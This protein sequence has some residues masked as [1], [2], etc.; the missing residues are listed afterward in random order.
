MANLLL[1]L[2][3]KHAAALDAAD[4]LLATVGARPMTAEEQTQYDGHLSEADGLRVQL[5]NHE[6]RAAI[7][8]IPSDT[9]PGASTRQVR[10]FNNA[11]DKPWGYDLIGE[12]ACD[13]KSKRPGKTARASE[14]KAWRDKLAICFG[15]YL[16][17]V[18]LA[19]MRQRGRTTRDIDIRLRALDTENIENR[20]IPAGASEKVPSDGGF[21]IQEDFANE[22]LMLIHE[23]GVIEPLVREI[24]LSADT[25]SIKIPAINE[26]SRQDGYRWGGIQAFWEDEAQQLVGS[27]PG[28]SQVELILKKLTG[29]FYA[30]NEVLADARALG[31]LAMQGFAE[32]FGF[33]IDDGIING[34]G[35]GQLQGILNSNA[36]ITVAKTQNQL[37]QTFNFGN[38]KSMWGRL[39]ARSRKNAVWLI[40]QDVEPQLPGLAQEVG[41]GG[42]PVFLPA[43]SALWG[44]AQATPIVSNVEL[45]DYA[46]MLYGRPVV[47]V[48]QCQTL[49]TVGDVILF[50][51]L[52]YLM[53]IKGGIQA[54]SSMHVRFLT[55][56]MTYR[57][58]LRRDSALWWKQACLP[59]NGTNSFSPVIA[60]A[61]RS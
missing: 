24:P 21:L 26:L 7:T 8:N 23:T 53:A 59:K 31:M 60:L 40:N 33:K 19:D 15:D 16:T 5:S 34:T 3:Q 42:I 4:G 35:A 51:P 49:G 27:K 18:R 32:E 37:A 10:V 55:D 54:A 47:V 2:K 61:T 22:I 6:R 45:N 50:D 43:G 11:V 17:E 44:S 29:L 52:Q 20:A 25:N 12:E 1:E 56:E 30:T 57:W 58:I 28:F 39:W 46:G 13:L 41:T 48:E 36:L 14:L 9:T 38:V